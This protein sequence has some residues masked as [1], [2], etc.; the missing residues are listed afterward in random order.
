MLYTKLM[1]CA[2]VLVI[3]EGT[4]NPCDTNICN[5]GGTCIHLYDDNVVCIC[6]TG[7]RGV[8]CDD[9]EF[10]FSGNSN[11][12]CDPDPCENGY[13]KR[14][15]KNTIQC[16]CDAGYSGRFCDVNPCD[17]NIC[18]NGGTCIHL[19]D[20]IVVCTCA[21]GYRGVTCDDK[22]F[23]FSG[24]SND[25]CDPDPCENGN[26]KRLDKN[27]IQCVCDAGYS[28]RFCDGKYIRCL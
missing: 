1:L 8:T 13:C 11:D 7:Y 28:G 22:E 23:I 6:A 4:D 12:P 26:C 10:I 20:D 14:L 5:N 15:N 19:Y 27:T 3:A 25:P 16:V 2:L 24:N 21:T 9:E 17:T 18:N